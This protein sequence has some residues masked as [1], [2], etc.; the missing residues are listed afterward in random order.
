MKLYTFHC[1]LP[2]AQ[3]HD[4][5]VAGLCRN[6]Q[7]PWQRFPLH[8]QRMVSRRGEWVRQLAKDAFAIVLHFA[9]FSVKKLWRSN[10]FSAERR[11]YGLVP[12]ANSKNREF[13][14]QLLD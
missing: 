13:P 5:T 10:Y 8:N 14:R 1:E 12:K 4:D 2:V 9:C 7:I 3:P 11:T 6:H